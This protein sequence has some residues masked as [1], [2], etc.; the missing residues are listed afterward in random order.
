MQHPDIDARDQPREP[1]VGA[2][3]QLARS[4]V[5]SQ[6][7]ETRSVNDLDNTRS[8]HFGATADDTGV[9]LVDRQI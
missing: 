3:S 2:G 6:L 8:Q 4:Q 7:I 1:T 9:H 5:P